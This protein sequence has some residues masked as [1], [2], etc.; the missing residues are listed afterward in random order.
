MA[1]VISSLMSW[2]KANMNVQHMRTTAM[3]SNEASISV[4]KKNG[5][6]VEKTLPDFAVKAGHK[7]GLHVLE[8]R[9]SS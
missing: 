9:A 7:V 8:W 6:M 2:A 5:F 1:A 3:E 4:L